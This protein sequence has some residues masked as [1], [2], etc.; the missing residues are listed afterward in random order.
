MRCRAVCA[1]LLIA[2]SFSVLSAE[3]TIYL[4]SAAKPLKTTIKKETAQGLQTSAKDI[5]P[6]EVIDIE[7][8]VNPLLVRTGLYRKARDTEKDSLEKEGSRK[9]NIAA[10]IQQY[11]DTLAKMA[12]GQASARRNIEYRIAVLKARQTME[13]GAPA[14]PAIQKLSEFAKSHP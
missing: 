4:K 14:D 9:S 13:L 5:A 3:E 7:Y 6:E 12:T 2:V 11:E 1:L 10:A 8:E